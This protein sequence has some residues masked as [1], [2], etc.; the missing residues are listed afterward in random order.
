MSNPPRKVNTTDTSRFSSEGDSGKDAYTVVYNVLSLTT[1]VR[2]HGSLREETLGRWLPSLQFAQLLSHWLSIKATHVSIR[3]KNV[4]RSFQRPRFLRA[5]LDYR[6][7]ARGD[8]S[9]RSNQGQFGIRGALHQRLQTLHRSPG[10]REPAASFLTTPLGALGASSNQIFQLS[11]SQAI[12]MNKL[13]SKR[14]PIP[15]QVSPP[16]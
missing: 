12:S 5:T 10:E 16:P 4:A 13:L 14:S 1:A 9:S 8:C 3:A 15:A 2:G 7:S 6:K 11:R